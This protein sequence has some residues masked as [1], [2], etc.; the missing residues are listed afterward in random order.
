M[1]K[2]WKTMLKVLVQVRLPRVKVFTTQTERHRFALQPA[3]SLFKA[4]FRGPAVA[5]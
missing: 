5:P 2:A 4:A 3:T 1:A